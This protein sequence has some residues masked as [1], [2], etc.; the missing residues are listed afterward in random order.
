MIDNPISLLTGLSC[1]HWSRISLLL[2]PESEHI[3][4]FSDEKCPHDRYE[5][6]DVREHKACTRMLRFARFTF[7][8]RCVTNAKMS[9]EGLKPPMTASALGQMIPVDREGRFRMDIDP[10]GKVEFDE[11]RLTFIHK[12]PIVYQNHPPEH[13]FLH[14]WKDIFFA[15]N[16]DVG[17]GEHSMLAHLGTR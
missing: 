12:R 4:V 14:W 8:G 11:R 2:Q 9:L 17:A 16:L 1:S 7:E 3:I 15:T 13:M 10:N 6:H 5:L